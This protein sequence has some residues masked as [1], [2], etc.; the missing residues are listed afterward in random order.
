[1]SLVLRL[2][3]PIR[4]MAGGDQDITPRGA[5]AR[6]VLVLLAM[7]PGRR[8][9][10]VALQDKLYS[11][12]PGEQGA[13][14]LRQ[15]LRDL[16]LALAG[17][18]GVL[19]SGPGWLALSGAVQVD[20]SPG[21]SAGRP[22]EFAE[23]LDVAD[24]EFDDWLRDL[25]LSLED[26]GPAPPSPRLPVLAVFEPEGADDQARLLGAM[27]VHEASAKAAELIPSD[28]IPGAMLQGRPRGQSVHAICLGSGDQAII[29]VMLR[30]L[31]TGQQI[32]TQRHALPRKGSGPA[33]RQALATLTYAIVQAALRFAAPDQPIFPLADLFSFTRQRLIRADERLERAPE[34][35]EGALGLSMRAYLRYTLILER[36]THDPEARL[37]EAEGF[38]HR[39][40]ALAPG[41]ATVLSLS[42]L[43]RSWKRDVAGALDLSRLAL[44]LCPDSD[45]ARHVLSQALTDAGRDREALAMALRAGTGP[46]ALIGQAT[47]LLRRMV[48]QMR[49]GQLDHAEESAAAALAHAPDNRPSLRFL[50]ALRYRRGDEAGTVDA[51]SRLRALEPD[52]TLDLMASPDYPVT[53]LRRMGL[54]D[55]TRSGL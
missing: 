53:T 11:E 49:L 22:A 47:W 20:L 33:L 45:L 30:D 32:M 27:L 42:A 41:D 38:L 17:H 28:M 51:L 48:S 19:E 7:A 31:A 6:A 29:M 44:R 24:P 37:A 3:G 9:A 21:A 43:L 23:G 35:G 25:R 2:I 46:M 55:V 8:M 39:A 1:M 34:I 54:L 26:A 52:F 18:A 5:K 36:Q 12:S 14:A 16:R 40:R 13:A 50:A 4:L 15:L 10:R